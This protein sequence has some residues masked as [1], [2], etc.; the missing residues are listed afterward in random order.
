M[1]KTRHGLSGPRWWAAAAAALT[2]TAGAL[3]V[4]ATQD[5]YGATTS[6]AGRDGGHR[7]DHVFVIML[8]NHEAD[9]VVG[10]PAAPYIT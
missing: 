2:V 3:T 1:Q 6:A 10:D 9:H 4:A 8:E 5:S 7:L